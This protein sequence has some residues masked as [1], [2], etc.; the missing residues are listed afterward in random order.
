MAEAGVGRIIF[1]IADLVWCFQ[2]TSANELT[3]A[4][5]YSINQSINQSIEVALV[6][7]LLQG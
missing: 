7:E 6:A 1:F 3:E 2:E 4:N 5:R